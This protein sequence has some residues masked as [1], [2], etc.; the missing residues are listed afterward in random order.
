VSIR[1]TFIIEGATIIFHL[2][3]CCF[4]VT[5]IRYHEML[6]R[7]DISQQ[8]LPFLNCWS[9][10]SKDDFISPLLVTT[11]EPDTV[12]INSFQPPSRNIKLLFVF[13]RSCSTLI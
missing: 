9:E 10:Q 13:W 12:F 8:R 7:K 3:N 6:D 2:L 11:V 4:G 5:H 1:T